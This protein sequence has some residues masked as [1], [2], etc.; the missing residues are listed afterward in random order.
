MHVAAP[1]E[2]LVPVSDE[3]LVDKRGDTLHGLSF[4]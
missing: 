3:P 4:P 2:H 1:A